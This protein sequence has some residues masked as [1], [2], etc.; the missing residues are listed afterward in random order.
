MGDRG[1]R[2]SSITRPSK[3]RHFLRHFVEVPENWEVNVAAQVEKVM[4]PFAEVG[5]VDTSP[6]TDGALALSSADSAA[7]NAAEAARL[8]D[9]AHSW[10]ITIPADFTPA[11]KAQVAY[12]R[13]L[14]GAI[15][16]TGTKGMQDAAWPADLAP[17]KPTLQAM[18]ERKLIVRR[19]RAWHLKRKWHA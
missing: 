13:E 19:Q 11:T 2:N 3:Y 5:V 4:L 8:A 7:V 16:L 9:Y 6:A 14:C 15:S 10:G 12:W 17:S 18:S 1:G